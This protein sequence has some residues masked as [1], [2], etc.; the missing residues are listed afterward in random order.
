MKVKLDNS[1]DWSVHNIFEILNTVF[2]VSR[3]TIIIV[4]HP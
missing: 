1:F 2:A 4:I 3:V